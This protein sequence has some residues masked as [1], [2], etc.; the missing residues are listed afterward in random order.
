MRLPLTISKRQEKNPLIP[1]LSVA[2]IEWS[3]TTV[4][5]YSIGRDV[6]VLFLTLKYHRLHP[7]Y[8]TNRIRDFRGG[9]PVRLLLFLVN[10]ENPDQVISR[11]T[12]LSIANS[13]NLI[14]AFDYEE[15]S[16]W[17][18]SLY[19]TQDAP[20]ED[21]KASN[22]TMR[23]MAIDALNALGTS[24][25]EAESLLSEIPVLADILCSS[26]D[27]L[28]NTCILSEKKVDN[29]IAVVEEPFG[30]LDTA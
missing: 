28:A 10:D 11:L 9:F 22:E 12:A 27:K 29:I 24:K 16:R 13:M 2:E 26:K 4:A 8:L 15:A 14:L 21:L 20:V 5:D 23:E 1:L 17:I 19:T 6:A 30:A 7:E 3:E 18:L 25:K